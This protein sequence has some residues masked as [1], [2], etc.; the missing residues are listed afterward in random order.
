MSTMQP[1]ILFVIPR[2]PAGSLWGEFR[3]K[4]PALGLLTLAAV[5][6]SGYETAFVD[7]NLSELNFACDADLIAI[8]LMT[9]L[10]PRGYAI[11]DAFRARGKKVVMGGI[12]AS[13][14]PDEA[15]QHSDA[16]VVGEGETLWPQLLD[17]CRRGKMQSI[18]RASGYADISALPAAR[19]E[20]LPRRGYLTN[21]TIQFARGCPHNC[22]Y[23]SVTAFLGHKLRARSLDLF[24]SEILALSE[25]FIFIVDDNIVANRALALQL[26]ERLQGSGKWWGSQAPIT[27]ADDRELL[28]RMAAAGCK[29]LFI[30][31]ESL[32]QQNLQ[33]MGKGFVY[34]ARHAERIK[35]IQEHGIGIQGSF[36]LGCDHDTQATVSELY[37]FILKTRVNAFLISVL[38][39]FPG[40]RLTARL[41]Q[42]GRVL[43]RDWSLYDMNTVVFRPKHF[44]PDKLQEEY[45]QLNR[46]LYTIPSIL[47]R[48]VSWQKNMVI[49]VPQNLGFRSAWQR[50]VRRA[51]AMV[52]V[53]ERL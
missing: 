52:E 28:A 14:F 3:Y 9:P 31:F 29:A 6:P 51:G 15:L 41:E 44:T 37:E 7:E 8:S 35:R 22:E 19:R 46:A 12:H 43:S 30:G 32:D 42:E 1:K 34:A 11:G 47:K 13:L 17:D 39:P 49:F 5:T 36:I 53:S 48:A 4:F 26:F 18:Y 20:L 16:V 2:W 24:A 10:A 45:D 40:T 50:R 27:V 25:R 21:G 38:T 23:C 33:Q